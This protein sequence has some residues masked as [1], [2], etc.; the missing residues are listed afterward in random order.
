M[1]RLRGVDSVPAG[2]L[3]F[4]ILAAARSGETLGARWNEID[5]GARLWTVPPARIKSK[6]EHRVPL[7]ERAMT[8]LE[9]PEGR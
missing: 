9:M 6:R 1:G 2:A 7:S 3:E 4:T 8:I 5:L